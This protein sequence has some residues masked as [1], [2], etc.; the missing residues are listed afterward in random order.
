[1]STQPHESSKR[2]GPSTAE[3][4]TSLQFSILDLLVLLFGAA[5]IA[6]L[7]RYVGFE[8]AMWYSLPL[9]GSLMLVGITRR[10]SR[11]FML[12]LSLLSLLL[13]TAL[14][15]SAHEFGD[16]ATPFQF[17]YSGVMPGV[18]FILLGLTAG[19]FRSPRAAW[20]TSGAFAGALLS[21][22]GPYGLLWYAAANYSGGGA[23]IGL[24]LLMVVTPVT[25]PIA[26]TAGAGLGFVVY[27]FS[28]TRYRCVASVATVAQK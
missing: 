25:V 3:H 11:E 10:S 13:G 22:A 20:S 12:G 2:E 27:K 17:F 7:Y 19:V 21:G 24:G 5:I 16:P 1:M 8:R 4:R 18:P 14:S 23:N 6:T 9:G 28:S 26:M 15:Y